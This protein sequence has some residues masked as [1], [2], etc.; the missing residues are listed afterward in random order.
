MISIFREQIYG[1][2]RGRVGGR[3]KLGFGDWHV[4]TAIFKIKCIFRLPLKSIVMNLPVNTR[5]KGSTPGLGKFHMLQGNK[6]VYHNCWA[7]A[8]EPS[9]YTT[10]EPNYWSPCALE[11]IFLNKRSHQM[12]NLHTTREYPL[13]TA[14][15]ESSQAAMKIQHSQK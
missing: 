13:L 15:R 6:L 9:S 12:R 7:C 11:P 3:A 1:Y 14:T 4:Q 5:D 2:Q 8:L 10:V